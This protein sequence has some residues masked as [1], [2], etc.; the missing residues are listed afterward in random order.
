MTE[1]GRDWAGWAFQVEPDQVTDVMT[2]PDGGLALVEIEVDPRGLLADLHEAF[3]DLPE[4]YHAHNSIHFGE[5]T[6]AQGTP[7]HNEGLTFDAHL[8]EFSDRIYA[9]SEALRLVMSPACDVLAPEVPRYQSALLIAKRR[10]RQNGHLDFSII[11]A[12]GG[13]THAGFSVQ[14]NGERIH[15]D[16]LPEHHALLMRGR[17]ATM[18]GV[19]HGAQYG[20]RNEHRI[21]L[22]GGSHIWL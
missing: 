10:L 18:A 4:W 8:P 11:E 13:A 19:K 14:R 20:K 9:F 1:F 3:L 15:L 7:L 22:L 2:D 17:E 12:W 21:T 6:C 16:G 5:N